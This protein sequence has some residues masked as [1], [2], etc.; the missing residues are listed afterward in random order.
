[1]VWFLVVTIQR[2]DDIGTFKKSRFDELNLMSRRKTISRI[3]NIQKYLCAN[4]RNQGFKIQN[5][6]KLFRPIKISKKIWLST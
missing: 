6:C 3:K 5:Q 2:K 4:S 1:M